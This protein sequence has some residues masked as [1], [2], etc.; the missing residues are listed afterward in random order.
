MAEAAERIET[1]TASLGREIAGRD[2]RLTGQL[3]VTS[4]DTLASRLVTGHF[5]R[6]RQ[7]HP[8]IVVELTVDNR[9]LSLSRREA[10]IA[11]RPAR[12]R[13][14]DLFGRKL[15]DIAWAVY[16]APA[17]LTS[18]SP[19]ENPAKLA[20]MPMI[21]WSADANGIPA[22]EWLAALVTPTAWVYRS[23]SLVNQFMAAKAGIGLAVLPCYLADPDSELQ[24]AIAAPISELMRELWIVTHSDLRRTARVRAFFDVVGDGLASE[25][26]LFAGEY[27]RLGSHPGVVAAGI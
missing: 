17:L 1:E 27:P 13:E 9:V 15:A 16:G 24:R 11:L 3:R 10:D 18:R 21:G 7:M 4:S 19:F 22:S 20:D 25:R 26:A 23:N 2:H 14:G 12:P 8:G 5:A 6:F